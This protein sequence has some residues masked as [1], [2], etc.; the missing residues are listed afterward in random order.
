MKKEY[1]KPE[2]TENLLT[3]EAF[4]G[5]IIAISGEDTEDSTDAKRRNRSSEEEEEEEEEE[6]DATNFSNLW[7]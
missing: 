1:F 2:V 3:G 7:G 4:L 6:E 5:A